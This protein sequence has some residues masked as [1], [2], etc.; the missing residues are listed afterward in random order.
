MERYSRYSDKDGRL[1]IVLARWC[2]AKEVD[3][4]MKITPK[5]IDLLDVGAEK[6]NEVKV[7]DFD[8]FVSKGLL[9]RIQ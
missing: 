1:H 6:V 9:M 5:T 2:S 7:E 4:A 8:R 3:G